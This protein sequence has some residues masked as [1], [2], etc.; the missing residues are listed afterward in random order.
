MCS[1]CSIGE[2]KRDILGADIASVDPVGRACSAFDP[3]DHFDV[4]AEFTRIVGGSSLGEDRDF[5]KVA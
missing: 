1:R 5:G 2:D 3:A 4:P